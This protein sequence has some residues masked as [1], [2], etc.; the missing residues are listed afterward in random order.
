MTSK[1]IEIL[2]QDVDAKLALLVEVIESRFGK[3][4]AIKEN[5]RG[6]F[7][8]VWFERVVQ[9]VACEYGIRTYAMFSRVRVER[10]AEARQVAMFI[11]RK[12][13]ESKLQVIGRFFR[14]HHGTVIHACRRVKD[15]IDSKQK[16]FSERLA[17]IEDKLKS[18]AGN[19]QKGK[20]GLVS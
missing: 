20:T 15:R 18:T 3:L 10:L 4:D 7:E 16:G 12:Q 5:Y 19:L 2:I 13:P 9:V 1:E 17:R 6:D 14:R 11:C 8:D